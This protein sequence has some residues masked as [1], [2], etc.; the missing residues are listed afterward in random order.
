MTE[1]KKTFEKKKVS[2]KC[3]LLYSGGLDTSVLCKWIP[4]NYGLEVVALTIDVGQGD[5]LEAVKKKAVA[6]GVKHVVVDAKVEF[7]EKFVWPA[8]MAN[9]VYE[10]AYPVSTSLARPLLAQKAVEVAKKTGCVA[11]AH[12]CTGKGNDQVRFDVTVKSLAPELEVV[13]PIREWNM[14]RQTELKYAQEHG[15]PVPV[16][17]EKNYSVDQNLW[18]R[19]VEGHWLEDPFAEP[20][21]DAYE[22]TKSAGDAPG[23]T[24][25]VEI[26][27]EGGVPKK[28]RWESK[29]KAIGRGEEKDAVKMILKMNEIA[30]KNGIGRID[31][32]EDRVVGLKTR[33]VYECPA[34]VVFIT[35]HRDLEKLVLTKRELEFKQAVDSKWAD[36]AYNGLWSDPLKAD[37]DAFVEK[38]NEKVKGVVRLK[39]WK[40]TCAVAGRKSANALY[41]ENLATYGVNSSFDQSKAEGFIELYGLQTRMANRLAKKK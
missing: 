25:Y 31:H 24:T 30:G 11:V 36:L 26:E 28:V 18:G 6:V 38:A 32:M 8:V 23:E 40:G 35:A 37:L 33:E 2:G 4:E 13:A 3:V 14:D 1:L 20:R 5:D 10:G 9:A 22:W 39:L 15:I 16:T 27:F 12:G 21:E 7:V 41:D 29:D 17:L 19:S 34:A